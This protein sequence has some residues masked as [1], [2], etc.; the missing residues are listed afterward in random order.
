MV[1]YMIQ[2]PV[3]SPLCSYDDGC[4]VWSYWTSRSFLIN[5]TFFWNL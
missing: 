5:A 1:D 2:Q 3:F 4:H